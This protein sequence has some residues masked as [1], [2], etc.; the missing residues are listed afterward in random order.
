MLTSWTSFLARK[1]TSSDNL[2]QIKCQWPLIY[3][4][5]YTFRCSGAH[6][7]RHS[8]LWPSIRSDL[9]NSRQFSAH[10]NASPPFILC[11]DYTSS[12]QLPMIAHYSADVKD[13]HR[14]SRRCHPG[15]QASDFPTS[16]ACLIQGHYGYKHTSSRWN[17]GAAQCICRSEMISPIK[18]I[19]I[20]DCH[21]NQTK[22]IPSRIQDWN[23]R[24]R[25]NRRVGPRAIA[26]LVY[27]DMAF[28]HGINAICILAIH[29]SLRF[30]QNYF[31]CLYKCDLEVDI[32][33]PLFLLLSLLILVY[34]FWHIESSLL[35]S[36]GFSIFKYITVHEYYH[37][38]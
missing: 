26:I 32:D 14:R 6:N 15:Q 35:C 27:Q 23:D 30:W 21:L 17:D 24:S 4:D 8:S 38:H 1:R 12:L 22:P 25:R 31:A 19:N 2:H 34:W 13:W 18:A 37:H 5:P 7:D 10:G 29:Q 9:L 33:T 11:I 28:A 3:I 36:A 20:H 16:I